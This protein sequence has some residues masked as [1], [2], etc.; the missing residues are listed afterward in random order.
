MLDKRILAHIKPDKYTRLKLYGMGRER[1]VLIDTW[2]DHEKHAMMI[3]ATNSFG[4]VIEMVGFDRLV[5]ASSANE[6]VRL[7]TEATEKAIEEITPDEGAHTAVG[8]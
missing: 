3:R 5:N 1:G 7:L 2:F 8:D 6:V 4:S